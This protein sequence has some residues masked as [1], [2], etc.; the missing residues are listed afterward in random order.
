MS[1]CV[2]G[3]MLGF[4]IVVAFAGTAA[5]NDPLTLG[6]AFY[7]RNDW[8]RAA[9]FF[10]VAALSSTG[11][12]AQHAWLRAGDAYLQARQYEKAVD[13]FQEA[14]VIEGP[15]TDMAR[16]RMAQSWYLAG[17]YELAG[18]QFSQLAHARAHTPLGYDAALFEALTAVSRGE[19]HRAARVYAALATTSGEHTAGLD[20]LARRAESVDRLPSKST[21]LA[22]TLSA[23]VPGAG[24]LYNGDWGEAGAAFLTNTVF[25]LLIWDSL[26]KA[27]DLAGRPH[28]GWAYTNTV[29][30]SFLGAS[31]YTGN[32]Y[33]AALGA[34]RFNRRQLER[35]QRD[36]KDATYRLQL[37]ELPI[38]GE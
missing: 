19:F 20:D 18:P 10:Q 34:K 32:I 23:F 29:L 11:V 3:S 15:L 9:T 21:R 22:A 26:L 7:K 14:A 25:G 5:A 17:R 27:R 28:R 13:W 1:R 16:L 35:L 2:L 4:T 12:T 36:L 37:I 24:Q 31:F 30:W 33:G 38:P 8:Y 6:D